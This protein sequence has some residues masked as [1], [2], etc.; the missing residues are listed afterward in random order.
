MGI[1]KE[2]ADEQSKWLKLA[3][4][5]SATVQFL[6]FE[7]AKSSFDD[8]REVIRYSLEI[9]GRSISLDSGSADLATAL[10]ATE[11]G[12]WIKLTRH[13]L[14]NKTKYTIEKLT[15]PEDVGVNE[16]KIGGEK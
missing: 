2:W 4:G 1:L 8:D 13:G 14:G 5:E 12:S 10:D 15:A 16:V 9:N 6:S 3:D 11:P 7:R